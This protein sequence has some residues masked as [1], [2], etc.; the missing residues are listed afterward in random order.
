VDDDSRT[1]QAPRA[2]ET[3]RAD[4]SAAG[5][6][7]GTA[8]TAASD[9]TPA[10]DSAA[11]AA[12]LTA[13]VVKAEEAY[14]AGR[15]QEA[16]T[17]L[18][19]VLAQDPNHARAL[20]SL[21]VVCHARGLTAEARSAYERLLN[22]EPGDQAIRK[23]LA[24]LL[25]S[26]GELEPARAELEKLLALNQNEASLWLLLARLENAAGRTSAAV[27]RAQRALLLQPG[28]T[29]A[30]N[31]LEQL[32]KAQSAPPAQSVSA[33]PADRRLQLC[34][35]PGREGEAALMAPFL[36]AVLEVSLAVSLKPAA[37][38]EAVGKGGVVWLEGT[39]EG[40]SLAAKEPGLLDGRRVLL[41]LDKDEVLS[42]SWRA[43]N[44]ERVTDVVFESLFLRD[45]FTGQKPPLKSGTRLHVVRRAVDLSRRPPRPPRP[46]AA[47]EGG[48][49][50]SASALTSAQI[51]APMS[52]PTSAQASEPAA[53]EAAQTSGQAS[54]QTS[55]Q[56]FA[57]A[58]GQASALGAQAGQPAARL[59]DASGGRPLKIVA[60]GPHDSTV[61]LALEAFKRLRT[62]RPEL[63]L[64]L[65][66]PFLQPGLEV[67]AA[68]YV[69]KTGLAQVVM[70]DAAPTDYFG[71][72]ADKDFFLAC[73]LA[74]GGPGP[75]EALQM[76]LKLLLRSCPG[77]EEL[78]PAAWLWR[79]FDELDRRFAEP[80]PTPEE[81]RRH[82][83]RHAP[84]AAATEHLRILGFSAPP[85]GPAGG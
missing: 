44:L 32:E 42:G 21:G 78:F 7:S 66:G 2:D 83:A 61:M 74:A 34:C 84:R 28:L 33:R 27:E 70:L 41:R 35:S 50:A 54:G 48:R 62:G 19:R 1:P 15:P 25:F 59:D 23:N 13:A 63:R 76:G 10:P 72:L 26:L 52:A 82:L 12:G 56:T 38:L 67:A 17:L 16:L 24:L 49:I 46:A 75:A 81:A 30:Q 9:P 85:V 20:R 64:H 39:G 40:P 71:Y 79:D 11:L 68:H 22:L 73:P 6:S 31:F 5:S 29:E 65:T 80:G 4:G 69:I 77:Q 60:P 45:T 18:A 37:Y 43:M 57:Q 51:L 47:E 58:S 55:G 8:R 3:V 14:Q 36:S 53:A